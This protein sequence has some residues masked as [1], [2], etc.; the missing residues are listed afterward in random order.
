MVHQFSFLC[1]NNLLQIIICQITLICGWSTLALCGY[2]TIT[3][4]KRI[5]KNVSE[6]NCHLTIY[7]KFITKKIISKRLKQRHEYQVSLIST[8]NFSYSDFFWPETFQRIII[9]KEILNL[10]MRG[11]ASDVL[12]MESETWLRKTVSDSRTVTSEMLSSVMCLWVSLVEASQI[13]YLLFSFILYFQISKLQR[14]TFSLSC[15]SQQYQSAA[16][17]GIYIEGVGGIQQN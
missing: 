14:Q 1:S 12:G 11:T 8:F 7:I 9:L 13:F 4:G 17:E 16:F 3:K 10:L 2:S 15:F 5:K 6:I